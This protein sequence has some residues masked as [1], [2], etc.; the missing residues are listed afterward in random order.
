MTQGSLTCTA[1]LR[2]PIK[3]E[4]DLAYRELQPAWQ[5]TF[6]PLADYLAVAYGSTDPCLRVWHCSNR[7]WQLVAELRG[8]HTRTVRSVAFA[9][10]RKPLVLAAASFDGSISIWEQNN[11][12]E[13]TAQLEG[14]DSEVK[15]VVWNATGS[16]LASCGRDKTIWLWEA[17]LPA[18]VGGTDAV[19]QGGDFE[20]L[21][22]LNGHE[23]DV[24]CVRFAPSHDQWGDGAEILLS[25]SYDDTVRVW[26]EDAGDWYCAA[27]LSSVHSS[28]IWT[29]AVAPSGQRLVSGSDD[30][31]L[32]I[33]KCY[34][35]DE[36]REQFPEQAK[37]SNGLW[38]CVG[39]L[40]NAHSSTVYS[41]DYASAR[42]G[43]GRI[44]SGGGDN[45]L[46]IYRE[47]RTSTSDQPLFLAE[48]AIETEHGDVNCVR[49]HPFD[50]SMLASTGDDGVVRLW[51]YTSS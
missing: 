15:G 46:V 25:S 50:G 24:K 45:R 31:S 4:G 49:W 22:V 26:A 41:V 14:H 17:F 21:A 1:V 12:W 33:Y 48:L 5:C 39:K 23:Q 9:P 28:T 13:C 35:V 51:K 27:C 36:K 20:C 37:G 2:P 43:H 11:D 29:L 34:T 40:P 19:G 7:T 10:I 6:S 32:A 30:G 44:A 47:A 42:C 38:R 16:L 18:T 8:I 3:R